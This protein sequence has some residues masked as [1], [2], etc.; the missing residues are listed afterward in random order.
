MTFTGSQLQDDAQSLPGKGT[1]AQHTSDGRW[2]GSLTLTPLSV[3][4]LWPLTI[5]SFP[6]LQDLG[7]SDHLT[8]TLRGLCRILQLQEKNLLGQREGKKN[9]N[10]WTHLMCARFNY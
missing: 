5:F 1:G 7:R 10:N 8:V 6:D 3:E 4:P 9:P 2:V